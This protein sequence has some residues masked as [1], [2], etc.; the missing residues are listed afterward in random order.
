MS[1]VMDHPSFPTLLDA[2]WTAVRE[3]EVA[4]VSNVIPNIFDE[5]EGDRLEERFTEVG[6]LNSWNEFVGSITPQQMYEQYSTTH[7]PREYGTQI[8]ITRRMVDDDLSG[9]FNGIR[10]RPMVRSGL[11]TMQEHATRL[12]EMI[13]V[14]DTHFYVYSEGVP[15]A[16]TAHTTRTPNIATTTGF[17]N[18]TTAA[19]TPVALRAALINGRKIKSDTGKRSNMMYDEIFVPV[20]LVPR[21][22]EVLNTM[23][24]LDV[25]YLNENQESSRRTGIM[26]VIG[27]PYW[28]ATSSWVLS[29]SRMRKMMLL[30]NW[31]V[32]P[33]YGRITEFDTLQLK[34]RG[35]M[36]Y[37]YAACG[38]RWCYAGI[39][40]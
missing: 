20:D 1:S 12:F 17:S 16:S 18:L 7:R 40:S 30:W 38:W 8:I 32:R 11:V 13:N 26:K 14:V 35:Y 19:F 21:V 37:G 22:N 15:I 31:R 25:P 3:E 23:S 10:F 24:G 39:P 28:T 6:E 2:R 5:F 29:N 36:R 33:E 4:D 9:V 27:L 34:A